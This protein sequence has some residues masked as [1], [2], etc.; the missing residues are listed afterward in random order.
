MPWKKALR[1]YAKG[2][3]GKLILNGTMP[4]LHCK[5]KPNPSERR[6]KR[7]TWSGRVQRSLRKKQWVDIFG[8]LN[9]RRQEKQIFDENCG[10]PPGGTE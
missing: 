2:K 4:I 1:G 7:N 10:S 3:D 8:A 5:D 9:T 6:D